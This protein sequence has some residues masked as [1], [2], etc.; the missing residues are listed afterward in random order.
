MT[1]GSDGG[2]EGAQ[3]LGAGTWAHA[4]SVAAMPQAAS[5][6]S[7]GA[8]DSA[9]PA[10]APAAATATAAAEDEGAGGPPSKRP[11][12]A[13]VWSLAPP[14]DSYSLGP[15]PGM[16]QAVAAVPAPQLQPQELG[17]VSAGIQAAGQSLMQVGID[18]AHAPASAPSRTP[19]PLPRQLASRPGPGPGPGV[20]HALMPGAVDDQQSLFHPWALLQPPLQPQRWSHE[21]AR[22]R[23]PP[24]PAAD[25]DD[26][27]A[28]RYPPGL[29]PEP[30]YSDS[31][32]ADVLPPQRLGPGD[33]RQRLYPEIQTAKQQQQQ[34]QQRQLGLQEQ[35]QGQQGQQQRQLGL[36]EQQQQEQQQGQQQ[37]QQ[38]RPQPPRRLQNE[39]GFTFYPHD[40]QGGQN[41]GR[42]EVGRE[43]SGAEDWSDV[44]VG[45]AGAGAA[46]GEKGRAWPVR[47]PWVDEAEPWFMQGSLLDSWL[48]TAQLQPGA[49]TASYSQ[50]SMPGAGA[51]PQAPGL[52]SLREDRRLVG[53]RAPSS[54]SPPPLS[55]DAFLEGTQ[56]QQ[57]RQCMSSSPSPPPHLP[58]PSFP[59]HLLGQQ[60][61][62]EGQHLPGQQLQQEGQ[63]LPGQHKQH[64]GQLQHPHQLNS[65][66]GGLP[67]HLHPL[68]HQHPHDHQRPHDHQHPHPHQQQQ[69]GP[70]QHPLQHLHQH[71][72]L[73]EGPH[74][75]HLHLQL[76]S[77]AGQQQQQQSLPPQACYPHPDQQQGGP[78]L[79]L[80]PLPL[81]HQ[82]MAQVQQVQRQQMMAQDQVQQQQMANQQLREQA[83][84][85]HVQQQMVAQAQK[86]AVRE[87]AWADMQARYMSPP[88]KGPYIIP[89][90]W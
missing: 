28:P 24:L 20:P 44:E 19:S 68:D 82:L 72:Q 55:R 49:A 40:S 90:P 31:H 89:R 41:R 23:T 42:G 14:L 22:E 13:I 86:Q 27:D 88:P 32:P 34:R 45:G 65:L 36:Q 57:Q 30:H 77:Q 84:E 35:E 46:G 78:P 71:P 33:K 75:H 69:E 58:L 59:P 8:L 66:E 43:V 4:P 63:H 47:E 74:H 7:I 87:H 52:S 62:H 81:H 39:E 53:V 18:A 26:D 21:A 51:G 10:T 79:L 64:E 16:G 48:I 56:Q 60:Q 50:H 9:A 70:L 54:L 12:Q 76:G 83:H 3:E 73:L 61:Q 5:P 25:D 29:M 37:Q 38:G 17:P 1:H 85:L 2:R 6:D 67:D 11:R 80:L 15:G